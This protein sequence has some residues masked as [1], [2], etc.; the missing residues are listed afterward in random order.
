MNGMLEKVMVQISVE[1]RVKFFGGFF[2]GNHQRERN[3]DAWFEKLQRFGIAGQIHLNDLVFVVTNQQ[4]APGVD[5]F[6]PIRLIG[7]VAGLCQD[8]IQTVSV[9]LFRK[10]KIALCS[11]VSF[12]VCIISWSVGM[13]CS[14]CCCFAL[15]SAMKP[16]PA[17]LLPSGLVL[18]LVSLCCFTAVAGLTSGSAACC[19][20]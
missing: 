7:K 14:S 15:S 4:V 11:I 17:F 5:V 6:L 3:L 1:S 18:A 9:I 2:P 12:A 19:F 16:I 8:M 10:G 13:R 20:P